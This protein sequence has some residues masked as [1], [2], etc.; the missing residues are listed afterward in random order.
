MNTYYTILEKLREYLISLPSIQTVTSGDPSRIDND[1]QAIFPV[2]HLT[3]GVAE[4]QDNTVII[5]FS[6]IFAD[7]L[8]F[9]NEITKDEEVPFY[10]NDNEHDILNTQ[11]L[12]ANQL[13]RQLNSNKVFDGRIRLASTPTAEPFYKGH[14]NNLT[15]WILTF[16]V[17]VPDLVTVC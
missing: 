16:N 3:T 15:G 9:S 1:R 5:P 8:D 11:L 6:I 10:G 13:V 7:V 12:N 4:F 2:A 14:E 17:E